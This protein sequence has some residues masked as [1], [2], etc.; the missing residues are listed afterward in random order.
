MKKNINSLF[1]QFNKNTPGCSVIVLKNN[2]IVFQDS[3]GMANL[4]KS[5]PN[6]QNTAFRLASLTKPF[7]AMAIMLLVEKQ[8]MK[9]TDTLPKFFADFPTYGSSIT[10]EQ[11]LSHISGMPD[12]EKPLYK[13]F[14]LGDEPTI[15]DSL[16][17]LKK[18]EKY[19]FK[20]GTKYKYSDAGFVVLA[21]II[22]K[23]SG[24]R[25][26]DF[27]RDNI[28][29]P[30][31][32]LSTVVLDETKPEIKNQAIGYKKSGK[33]YEIWDYDLLNYI[34]GD[35]GIY[36]TTIDLAK[37]IDAW[38]T[39]KLVSKKMLSSALSNR[40]CR[41]GKKSRCGFSWFIETTQNNEYIYHDG[42]W[43]GFT[44]IIFWNK[45]TD[46]TI[47]VLTNTNIYDTE[48]KR[49]DLALNTAEYL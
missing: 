17:V 29:Q 35:E 37:W 40:I 43:V 9:L 34:V 27:L 21:L 12:H 2:L 5:I 38:K 47:I 36:S 49:L 39:E 7:T 18:Q 22:E 23:V 3:Y 48:K 13:K 19:L 31:N 1:S 41:N 24:K 16:S 10:I 20:P 32:M 28:F 8:L 44:N 30:L 33:T 26:A 4:E 46:T 25:Y 45:K 14:K 42:F 15:Y 11:L 6:E